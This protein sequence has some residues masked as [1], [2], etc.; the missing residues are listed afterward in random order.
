MLKL[1]R[2]RPVANLGGAGFDFLKTELHTGLTLARIAADSN[3]EDKAERNRKNA[4]LAYDTVQ[5]D[6]DKVLLTPDQSREITGLT[7]ELRKLLE[8]L[9]EKF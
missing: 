2:A 5:K 7:R 8:Q 1:A 6:R 9:G 3:H 4:R